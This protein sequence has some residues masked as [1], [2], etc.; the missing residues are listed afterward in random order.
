ML[1]GFALFV[2]FWL[3][4]VDILHVWRFR[5]KPGLWEVI[6]EWTAKKSRFGISIF[7]A[8]YYSHTWVSLRRVLIAFTLALGLG[9]PLGL[10]MGWYLK[11]KDDIARDVLTKSGEEFPVLVK[12][13]PKSEFKG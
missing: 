1:I 7:T 4:A 3:L 5:Y 13:L 12:H 11:F 2:G 8:E 6:E 10:F 9:V